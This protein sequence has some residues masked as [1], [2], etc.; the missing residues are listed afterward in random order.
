MDNKNEMYNNN[1]Q[2]F[3]ILQLKSHEEYLERRGIQVLKNSHQKEIQN[4]ISFLGKKEEKDDLFDQI[5]QLQ[6]FGFKATHIAGKGCFGNV[7]IGENCYQESFA[8]KFIYILN[9]RGKINEEL[10]YSAFKEV[11]IM[12]SL[13]HPNVVKYFNYFQSDSNIIIQMERCKGTFDDLL[14]ENEFLSVQSFLK[15]GKEMAEGIKYIHSQGLILRDL[16]PDNILINQLNQIKISDFG[17]AANVEAGTSYVKYSIAG[18]QL[19][20]APELQ[21]DICSKF[22]EKLRQKDKNLI[23]Q[24]T[25][26][27]IF[28][29]GLIFFRILGSKSI[30][31]LKIITEGPRSVGKL[32]MLEGEQQLQILHT[33]LLN[34][35]ETDPNQRWK[36]DQIIQTIQVLF[37]QILP[38]FDPCPPQSRLIKLSNNQFYVDS[39][40]EF[41][42]KQKPLD[43]NH[44]P[45]NQEIM[46]PSVVLKVRCQSEA[47]RHIN[48]FQKNYLV[49]E[50]NKKQIILELINQ[51]Q[52]QVEVIKSEKTQFSSFYEQLFRKFKKEFM[53]QIDG[54]LQKVI[55]N[56]TVSFLSIHKVYAKLLTL[57]EQI[58]DLIQYSYGCSEYRY[59]TKR[60]QQIFGLDEK[61]PVIDDN[62]QLEETAELTEKDKKNVMI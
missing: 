59:M 50:N 28:S 26:S 23:K 30:D 47:L 29:L 42:I 21:T 57:E 45:L 60:I 5:N 35:C 6:S 22:V 15:Y 17:L 7:L 33:M 46:D 40:L 12:K 32:I 55:Q 4:Y 19:Y 13:D 62:K 8:F 34:I 11:E 24:S 52:V 2:I 36:I 54:D 48:N 39:E 9:K 37:E 27:D 44:F 25:K 58:D 61:K 20:R 31:F 56:G 38:F 43:P 18:A 41:S 51:I 49:V 10:K 1:L 3:T 14:S 53:N 16:K